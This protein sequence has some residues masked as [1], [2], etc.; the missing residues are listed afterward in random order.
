MLKLTLFEYVLR[1]I[2]ESFLI[3]FIIGLICRN[4]IVTK[5]YILSSVILSIFQFIIRLLPINY[6]V[7]TLLGVFATIIIMVK[8][9]N[10]DI[11]KTI[12]GTLIAT[13]ILFSCE[14]VNMMM[15]YIRFGDDLYD[16]MTNRFIKIALG[17]PSIFV[18]G[19]IAYLF[20]YR[21]IKRGKL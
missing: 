12:R 4:R 20:R 15:L 17:M 5:N 2:P 6:G 18:F 21:L 13:L 11:T 10:T 14:W 7:H 19:I 8:I 1:S 3:V 9:N 16:L